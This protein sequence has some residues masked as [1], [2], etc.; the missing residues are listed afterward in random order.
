MG[1]G[2]WKKGGESLDRHIKA[3]FEKRK[4]EKG[5]FWPGPKGTCKNQ[6]NELIDGARK[7]QISK[8]VPGGNK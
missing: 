8:I 4:D 2:A 3:E 6:A 1:Q 5:G 7:R